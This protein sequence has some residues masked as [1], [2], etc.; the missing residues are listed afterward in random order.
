MKK[1]ELT[2]TDQETLQIDDLFSSLEDLIMKII[3][4][5]ADTLEKTDLE[6]LRIFIKQIETL[7]LKFLTEKTKALYNLVK[8]DKK[9]WSRLER[10]E[11][12]LVTSMLH[13]TIITIKSKLVRQND[14]SRQEKS[15][16]SKPVSVRQ[17]S[18]LEMMP[19]GVEGIGRSTYGSGKY[20]GQIYKLLGIN[21]ENSQ[22]ITVIDHSL[23]QASSMNSKWYSSLVNETLY[24]NNIIGN[25]LIIHNLVS[26]GES[27]FRRAPKNRKKGKVEEISDEERKIIIEDFARRTNDTSISMDTIKKFIYNPKTITPLQ[28]QLDNEAKTIEKVTF[29]KNVFYYMYFKDKED[30]QKLTYGT[31]TILFDKGDAFLTDLPL[32]LPVTIWD[33]NKIVPL[34]LKNTEEYQTISN[35]IY[36]DKIGGKMKTQIEE[37]ME[38]FVLSPRIAKKHFLK[39]Y[40]MYLLS[41]ATGYPTLTDSQWKE[42]IKDLCNG[43]NVVLSKENWDHQLATILI[44][45]SKKKKLLKELGKKRRSLWVLDH[46][47]NLLKKEGSKEF[48]NYV[49]SRIGSNA[50]AKEIVLLLILHLMAFDFLTDKIMSSLKGSRIL[51]KSRKLEFY[52]DSTVEDRFWLSCIPVIAQTNKVE[53]WEKVMLKWVIDSLSPSE[54]SNIS[55]ANLVSHKVQR[56]LNEKAKTAELVQRDSLAIF[57][58]QQLMTL[59]VKYVKEPKKDWKKSIKPFLDVDSAPASVTDTLASLMVYKNGDA[60]LIDRYE[61]KGKVFWGFQLVRELLT[62]KK[63][64][65]VNNLV[66]KLVSSSP[67]NSAFLWALMNDVYNTHIPKTITETLRRSMS[68]NLA[69]NMET[70]L[71]FKADDRFY[72]SCL[73]VI[74]E[75]GMKRK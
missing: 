47:E 45:A 22:F 41:H 56:K 70:Y 10:E 72:Y 68:Y 3:L 36:C 49:A 29:N 2:I 38:K 31:S 57:V 33:W 7:N 50:P 21:L 58:Q 63:L 64:D 37:K 15:S 60:K 18:T 48:S 8:G 24:L 75:K 14:F 23:L 54:C 43:D 39:F 30:V 20:Y 53:N 9:K 59:G 61:K 71:N 42:I 5:G 40:T 52:M 66:S 4:V 16:L 65:Q 44:F 27:L 28:I 19:L 67:R 26:E 25:K 73:A 62:K 55:H 17:T 51:E 13:Q 32:S 12:A 11:L 35:L 6:E 34:W 1:M 46:L 69:R 74:S